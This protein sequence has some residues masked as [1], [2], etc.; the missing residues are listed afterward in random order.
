MAIGMMRRDSS[1]SLGEEQTSWSLHTLVSQLQ[2]EQNPTSLHLKAHP[3]CGLDFRSL[4]LGMCHRI[5]E[6][7]NAA[8]FLPAQGFAW[9]CSEALSPDW[10]HP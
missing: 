10:I 9:W 6:F 1:M 4:A 5:T 3:G 8:V 2:T 7:A